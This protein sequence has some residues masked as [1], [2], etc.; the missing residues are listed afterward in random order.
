MD[1]DYLRIRN[2]TIFGVD[3][4][5]DKSKAYDLYDQEMDV[6]FILRN[7]ES[8][9]RNAINKTEIAFKEEVN[10]YGHHSDE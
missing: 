3:Y 6:Y 7:L 5:K 9:L 4:F 2:R 8:S 1:H 10:T